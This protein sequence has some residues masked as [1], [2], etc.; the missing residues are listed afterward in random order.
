MK[1]VGDSIRADFVGLSRA[2]RIGARHR[3]AMPVYHAGIG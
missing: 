3:S 2:R 1:D